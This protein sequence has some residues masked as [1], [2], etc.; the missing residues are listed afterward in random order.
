MK[1]FKVRSGKIKECILI[2]KEGAWF[3]VTKKQHGLGNDYLVAHSNKAGDVV[4]LAN[5]CS[6]YVEEIEVESAPGPDLT[7]L[8]AAIK[9]YMTTMEIDFNSGDTKADLLVKIET[10]NV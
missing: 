4:K 1:K 9:E 10:S 6:E 8:V 7:W 5:G 3:Y 2:Q